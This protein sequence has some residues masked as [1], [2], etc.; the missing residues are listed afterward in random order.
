MLESG[1]YELLLGWELGL[2]FVIRTYTEMW[3]DTASPVQYLG[4]IIQFVAP[5][6]R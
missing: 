6:Y 1:V 4:Q 3:F 2:R 5:A